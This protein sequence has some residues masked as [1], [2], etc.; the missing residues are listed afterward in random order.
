MNIWD[1]KA[2]LKRGRQRVLSELV[3]R[4]SSGLESSMVGSRD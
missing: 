4:G 1:L 3:K 2:T